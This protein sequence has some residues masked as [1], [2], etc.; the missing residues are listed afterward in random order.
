[1]PEEFEGQPTETTA[2]PPLEAPTEEPSS[3]PATP[4]TPPTLPPKYAG[5]TPEELTRVLTEQERVIGRQGHELGQLRDAVERMWSERHGQQTP[6]RP[7]QRGEPEPEFN[8]ER[9][10]D[11]VKA[12]IRGEL[13]K[14]WEKLEQVRRNDVAQRTTVAFNEGRE[15][16]KHNPVL[17]AGI[18]DE[19]A[20]GIASTLGPMAAQGQDVSD[21]LRNPR[22]WR[23][24]ALAIRDN[25]D[26]LDK[27]QPP[28]KQGMAPTDTELP[29]PARTSQDDEG[30]IIEDADRREYEEIHGQR[31]TDKQI[32]EMVK[33]GLQT[34]RRR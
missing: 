21:L 10:M 25:R 2:T 22:T 23:Y 3:V 13:S 14:A 15:I 26:E 34:T 8:Y 19:V 31:G 17:F 16:M 28:R 24:V 5:K 7:E 6:A 4:E 30:I 9:P 1:M 20:R 29:N 18:E 32:R 11:S 33:L 12:A 27:I